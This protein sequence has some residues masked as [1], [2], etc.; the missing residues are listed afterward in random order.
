MS[1]SKEKKKLY[2]LFNGRDVHPESIRWMTERELEKA[3]RSAE[4]CDDKLMYYWD[5][6]KP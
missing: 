2:G 1:N 6:I 3:Q 4:W 5:E